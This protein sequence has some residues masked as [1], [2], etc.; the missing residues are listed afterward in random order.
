MNLNHQ[1]RQPL[2]IFYFPFCLYWLIRILHFR[3]F[4]MAFRPIADSEMFDLTCRR[5][6]SFQIQYITCMIWCLESIMI[7]CSRWSKPAEIPTS[8]KTKPFLLNSQFFPSFFEIAR[9]I[10]QLQSSFI[11][12]LT[13]ITNIFI[14][15]NSY[16]HLCSVATFVAL[17]HLPFNQAF[18][19]T[20][21]ISAYNQ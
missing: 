12:C 10:R 3:F 20:F 8:S 17:T 21:W 13:H 9:P 1:S 18:H 2:L 15:S 7:V 19:S 6:T 14:V 11:L 5:L 16:Y 4:N